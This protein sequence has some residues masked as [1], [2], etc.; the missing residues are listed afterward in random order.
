VR[1]CDSDLRLLRA[2]DARLLPETLQPDE[3]RPFHRYGTDF[4]PHRPS[5]HTWRLCARVLGLDGVRDLGDACYMVERSA[6]PA[7]HAWGGAPPTPER[8]AFLQELLDHLPNARLL[9]LHGNS[10]LEGDGRWARTNRQLAVRFLRVS[11]LARPT[12]ERCIEGRR[13]VR[14]WS[15]NGRWVVS[16]HALS[17][18]AVS[19]AYVTAVREI[20]GVVR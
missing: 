3:L 12:L 8:C 6:H 19:A 5:G 18:R 1:R 9:L 20:V 13:W 11:T 16:T 15:R 2:I 7:R 17:W 10:D 4:S 14:A